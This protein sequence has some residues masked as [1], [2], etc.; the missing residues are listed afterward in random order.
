MLWPCAPCP[1]LTITLK[2]YVAR[3]QQGQDPSP[4]EGQ[5]GMIQASIYNAQE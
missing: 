2:F 4:E 1:M 3:T 5:P